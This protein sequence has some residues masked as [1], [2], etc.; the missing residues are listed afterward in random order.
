[1]ICVSIT[2]ESRTLAKVDLLNASRQGDLVELCLDR[3]ASPPDLQDI[4]DGVE[5]PVLISCRRKQDGGN[6]ERTEDERINWLRDAC[7]SNAAFVEVELD[8]AAAF[9]TTERRSKLVVASTS[10]DKPVLNPES[11]FEQAAKLKADV[12]KFTWPTP[13]LDTAWPLLS[14]I[15]RKP[16]IPVVGMGLGPAGVMF[17]LLGRK[18]GSPWIYAALERG[19]E[20]HDGQATVGDLDE[21]YAWRDIGAQT[22][23]VGVI[24]FGASKTT[25]VRIFNAGFQQLGKNM[26]CLP[27]EIG[28]FDK[29]GEMLDALKINAI[30]TSR[31]LG[32]HILPLAEHRE[33]AAGLG[34]NADLLLKRTEGWTAYNN[35]WRSAV[36]MLE[37]TLG[38]SSAEDRPLAGRKVLVF[39]T[40][41]LAQT[42][43]YGLQ[44]RKAVVTVSG[45]TDE[46]DD[47]II[48]CSEC[49]AAQDAAVNGAQ[50]LA[51]VFGAEFLPFNQAQESP[52]DVVVLAD[53]ALEMGYSTTELHP[54]Y[55]HAGMTVM[56]V[57]RMPE[58]SDFIVEARLH[59]C[60]V[61]DPAEIF[62][63]QISSQ[64][65]AI[66]GE[67]LPSEAVRDVAIQ[68][69]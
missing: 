21:I 34:R 59:G 67:A 48:F 12:I 41:R 29:M 53:A 68:T 31:P 7:N 44:Q 39:G 49:G 14:L 10:L 50:Q 65:K 6:W 5:K 30:F 38:K 24:G 36:R 15:S 42:L 46:D 25:T 61:V 23:F 37:R 32:E 1:M 62:L 40:G 17:S 28:R 35:L 56:D 8:C 9:T 55:L 2:P 58:A 19:M 66:T 52:A 20:T 63:D 54:A 18:H 69:G 3:L 51:D 33:E 45:L 11:L 47:E 27:I 60:R 13:T 22:Q 4:L 43:V 64:F 16:R 26:R 57:R